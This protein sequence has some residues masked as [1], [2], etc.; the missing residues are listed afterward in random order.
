MFSLLCASVCLELQV[1]LCH[2]RCIFSVNGS[3]LLRASF[4]FGVSLFSAAD[5][6]RSLCYPDAILPVSWL[7]QG[8]DADEWVIV[9]RYIYGLI[10][11]LV[12]APV[13][14]AL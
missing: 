12:F 10:Y 8:G 2:G 13:P 11:V 7:L 3:K 4:C 5:G 14:L 1:V 9:R 6:V